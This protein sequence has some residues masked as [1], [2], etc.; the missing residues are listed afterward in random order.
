MNKKTLTIIGPALVGLV[1][2]LILLYSTRGA[3]QGAELYAIHCQSCHM[4][5][6]EGLRGV[7]PPLAQA[8]Y[9]QI[10]RASLA[11]LIRYGAENPMVVN[12]I[13]YQQAMPGNEQL[14]ETDIANV[15]NYVL[16]SWGNTEKPLSLQEVQEQ[17]EACE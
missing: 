10:N 4:E 6:G 13:T 9:L 14:T 11:C 16:K 17:L 2:V 12:G 7:I 3:D 1:V 15:L 5:N 8:D